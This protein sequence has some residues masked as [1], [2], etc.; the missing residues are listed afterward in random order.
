VRGRVSKS[1]FL[2]GTRDCNE[3]KSNINK[4]L[5]KSH[6]GTDNTR[7][8]DGIVVNDAMSIV[9]KM[10]LAVQQVTTKVERAARCSIRAAMTTKSGIDNS[11]KAM[12]GMRKI[13]LTM[14]DVAD[15]LELLAWH[16]NELCSTLVVVNSLTTRIKQTAEIAVENAPH[17]QQYSEHSVTVKEIM[18]LAKQLDGK[19]D[20]ISSIIDGVLLDAE[21]F[22]EAVKCGSKLVEEGYQTANATSMVMEKVMDNIEDTSGQID[23]ISTSTEDLALLSNQMIKTVEDIISR[24]N[25]SDQLPT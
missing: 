15:A 9:N 21:K 16:T 4:D 24:V 7:E 23:K 13:T 12:K 5:I 11:R 6:D 20:R 3:I 22:T 1:A 14:T 2:S 10:S 25:K 18:Q 17:H 19:T 8:K